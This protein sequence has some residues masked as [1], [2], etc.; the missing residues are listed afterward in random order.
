MLEVSE[1]A[2]SVA[3]A[4]GGSIEAE[5]DPGV[6]VFGYKPDLEGVSGRE[7]PKMLLLAMIN[8]T[9]TK[10]A[11]AEDTANRGRKDGSIILKN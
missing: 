8:T 10:N 9:T 3:V 5:D 4:P 6:V 7:V 2:T 11:P 1:G